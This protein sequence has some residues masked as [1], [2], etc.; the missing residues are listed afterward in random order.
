LILLLGL[1]GT[2]RAW[3]MA[4][5]LGLGVGGF[6]YSVFWMWAGF[7]APALGST[8]AAKESLKWLAMPSSGAF[9]VATVT[10]LVLLIVACVR[11][12]AALQPSATTNL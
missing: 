8:G 9:V 3:T 7:R 11:R 2:S 12:G 1:L 5:G 4:V 10:V 6:G